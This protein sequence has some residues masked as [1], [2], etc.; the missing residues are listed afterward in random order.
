MT[1]INTTGSTCQ[2]PGG[3][4]LLYIRIGEKSNPAPSH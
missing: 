4:L 2:G 1:L 3:K